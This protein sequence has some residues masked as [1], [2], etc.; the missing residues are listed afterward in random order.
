M[1]KKLISSIIPAILIAGC[2]SQSTS[3]PTPT[4]AKTTSSTSHSITMSSAA[5]D[6]SSPITRIGF[7]SCLKEKDSMS[8]WNDVSAYNPE[9][10]V[11]LGDNV[12]GDLYSDDPRFK[13]PEMPYMRASYRKLKDSQTFADFRQKT[14]MMFTWDDHD[15]GVN[16][17][18]AEYPFK[19]KAEELFLEAWDI[20][21]NDVRRSRPGIYTSES[22]GPDGQKLQMILLDTRYF[23]GPLKKT[24]ERNAPLKER[25]VPSN[26]ASSTI[27]GAKQWQWLEE[28]LNK[29]ADLRVLVSSIQV[30][31]EGHGWEAWRTLPLERQKL[32]DLLKSTNANNTIIIS[33][34]RHSGAFYERSDV[35]GFRLLEMTTSSLNAPASIWRARSGETRIEPGPHRDGDPQFEANFGM[36]DIDWKARQARLQIVSPGNETKSKTFDF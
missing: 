36:M 20:P 12:Y 30:I 21:A 26:D 11:L 29:P 23:R 3:Q 25:Y 34:D 7:G 10:F 2:T 31:A 22:I 19:D 15:F 14:P 13:N 5:L 4:A 18:G 28:E 35:T 16:D 24:D 27:L 6:Y 17:G 8:I 9:L 1:K 32:Y 33:G